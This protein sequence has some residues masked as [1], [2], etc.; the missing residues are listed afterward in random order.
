MSHIHIIEQKDKPKRKK[1]DVAPK[2]SNGRRAKLEVCLT[3]TS[4]QCPDNNM[5]FSFSVQS[6]LMLANVNATTVAGRELEGM[7]SAS[8]SN[9][10]ATLD[11]NLNTN[12]NK[13][14]FNSHV[15]QL[16]YF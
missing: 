3:F 15:V 16:I 9:L 5:Y 1:R 13:V 8:K 14:C 11:K 2:P 6:G 4:A 10:V 7:S 12:V